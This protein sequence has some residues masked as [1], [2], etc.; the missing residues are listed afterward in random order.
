[1]KIQPVHTIY[2]F[3]MLLVTLLVTT[4]YTDIAFET[5]LSENLP[6]SALRSPAAVA[7]AYADGDTATEYLVPPKRSFAVS[8]ASAIRRAA[9]LTGDPRQSARPE[10]LL[11]DMEVG[12]PL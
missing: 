2:K 1:M 8:P 12:C 4:W 10:D 5:P 7:S 11:G 3:V 9:V 6:G